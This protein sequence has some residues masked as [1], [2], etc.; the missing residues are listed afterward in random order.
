MKLISLIPNLL[1][2]IEVKIVN[3]ADF[4]SIAFSM[5]PVI[6]SLLALLFSIKAYNRSYRSRLHIDTGEQ[7]EGHLIESGKNKG[8]F[9]NTDYLLISLSN[10]GICPANITIKCKAESKKTDI[11]SLFA[12]EEDIT[13]YQKGIFVIQIP[14]GETKVLRIDKDALK[15]FCGIDTAKDSLHA[16]KVRFFIYSNLKRIKKV[17]LFDFIGKPK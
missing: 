13:Y 15:K 9:D 10:I 2:P 16:S 14:S 4:W 17:H 3:G 6:I 5:L 7:H 11:T 8:E 1:T 12:V